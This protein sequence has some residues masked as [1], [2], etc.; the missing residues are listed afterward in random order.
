[1]PA[2]IVSRS[3][4]LLGYLGAWPLGRASVWK[5]PEPP[6]KRQKGADRQDLAPDHYLSLG[7]SLCG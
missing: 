3:G 1:M 4:L 6:Q 2:I 7:P 5:V